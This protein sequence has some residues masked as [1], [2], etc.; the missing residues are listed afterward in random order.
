MFA[1]LNAAP[2]AV[3]GL[4]QQ[5]H[6]HL[7]WLKFLQLIDQTGAADKQVHNIRDNYGTQ[8]SRR[9]SASS[10]NASICTPRLPPHR[11]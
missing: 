4:C 10:A 11:G 2:G 7:E 6:R 1:A 5:R 8:D 9:S 3:F